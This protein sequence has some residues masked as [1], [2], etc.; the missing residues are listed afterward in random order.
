MKANKGEWS[1]FYA[2]LKILD[3]RKLFAADKNLE[4]IPDKFFVFRRV[5]RTEAG[6][7]EKIFDIRNEGEILILDKEG[8]TLKKLSGEE[9]PS[10][11]ATIFRKI[12]AS[13][14]TTFEI[15]E[16][17]DLSQE[18]LCTKIKA[19]NYTKSDIEAEVFDRIT[20][21]VVPLGFSV[22]SAIGGASILTLVY[23][24]LIDMML[25]RKRCS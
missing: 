15:K 3:E 7:D 23:F 22:K 11:V 18:L 25:L 2:F 20:D 5:F 21:T 10:K 13:E 16:A 9:L 6:A 12:K 19:G 1:E 24:L 14:G 17:S 8:K 4:I